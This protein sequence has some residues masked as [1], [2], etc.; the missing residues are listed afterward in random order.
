MAKSFFKKIL[1]A[2][3]ALAVF[4]S[5]LA[6][7]P[8][9][10]STSFTVPGT[11]TQISTVDN[12]ASFP[13]TV[14][15]FNYNADINNTA[16]PLAANDFLFYYDH[17]N[18]LAVDGRQ[19][20]TGNVML[21]DMD[22][23]L[24]DGY[25]MGRSYPKKVGLRW[26]TIYADISYA[27]LFSED[28]A[29]PG[30]T[31]VATMT[32]GGGLFQKDAD[33]Y[34]EYDSSKNAAYY[35][36]SQGRFVLYD[37]VL[38]PGW[39]D[40]LSS[41][42]TSTGE[43]VPDDV[44]N[45]NFFPFN[46]LTADSVSPENITATA[47]GTTAVRSMDGADAAHGLIDCWFGMTVEFQFIMP[48]DGKVNG[49]DMIFHFQGDDD[50]Y[51]YIDDKLVLNVGGGHSGTAYGTVNFATGDAEDWTHPRGL[52]THTLHEIFG[53]EGDT[54]EDYSVHT[55]KFFY[56]ERFGKASQCTIRFN[57]PP[58]PEES[59]VIGKNLEFNSDDTE[60]KE[61][62]VEALTDSDYSFR[63]LYADDRSRLFIPEGTE[64]K[65]YGDAN[66]LV[67]TRNAGAG[68]IITVKQG[69]YAVIEGMLERALAAD[70]GMEYVVEEMIPN[71]ENI[72]FEGVTCEY[73]GTSGTVNT[74]E[75]QSASFVGYSSPALSA[76]EN[77]GVWF[78][79]TVDAEALP[80]DTPDPP[81]PP[82]P[83]I[84][85][86]LKVDGSVSG[87]GAGV[88]VPTAGY[89]SSA[90]F[91]VY[92]DAACTQ[93]AAEATSATVNG[94]AAGIFS[95]QPDNSYFLKETTVPDGYVD[96][97]AVI[98]VD[99]GEDGSLSFS[100]GNTYY[101]FSGNEIYVRNYPERT[102][103]VVKEWS[104]DSAQDRPSSVEVRLLS[105]NSVVDT[106]N[107]T[108]GG[109]WRG[110]VTVPAYSVNSESGAATAI[111]YRWE[112]TVP[113]GYEVVSSSTAGDTTTIT[114]RP[115]AVSVPFTVSCT[116][117]LTGRRMAEG[118]FQF[119]IYETGAD[120]AVA[121]DAAP[122]GQ[123]ANGSDGSFSFSLNL[124]DREPHYYVVREVAGSLSGVTYDD[125][126]YRVRAVA[127]K[128]GGTWQADI[129]SSGS[130]TFSNQYNITVPTGV[131]V[132]SG[133]EGAA[134]TVSVGVMLMLSAA[135]LIMKR[136]F[137]Y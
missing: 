100:G 4:A 27:Y 61:S 115:A 21:I 43:E 109:G 94:H 98:R 68:G 79:N 54:F 1:A 95:L 136:F 45:G 11:S 129:T 72:Y 123:A 116:K 103:N 50:T 47:D 137:R 24:I 44:W 83:V 92:S 126:D 105:G 125:H 67:A 121:E 36:P 58:I 59:L 97:Q 118:E 99:V 12:D 32:D 74:N 132:L 38:R 128:D 117:T 60:G 113:E 33:G 93:V 130:S 101:T 13:A 28:A 134:W 16:N 127:E 15:L 89:L 106:V 119:N 82:E 55:L 35:D 40:G 30:K 62:A 96:S 112:E 53:L 84:L 133:V 70:A 51:I 19:T 39:F 104:Q 75:V 122:I 71:A 120:Y 131:H 69:Q 52:E 42:Q 26:R 37:A 66:N 41:H 56:M 65:V 14:R 76:E 22:P 29:A 86:V 111:S 34:Y 73:S 6:P 48:K 3:A 2:T 78:T 77:E 17:G 9:Q 87:A 110:S 7:V 31:H 8:V 102:L 81:Q 20:D 5:G 114:N 25:P 90:V 49:E 63:V 91:T 85:K 80:D 107:L 18:N 10:A 88:N 23:E 64:Y 108:A 57:T 124:T 46:P 135:V